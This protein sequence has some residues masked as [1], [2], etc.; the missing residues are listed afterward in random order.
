MF[1]MM[2]ILVSLR[3]CFY[4]LSVRLICSILLTYLLFFFCIIPSHVK[5]ELEDTRGTFKLIDRKQTENVMA[6][7][8]YRQTDL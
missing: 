1:F 2:L 4:F 6:K 7:K 8:R 5:K 3:F